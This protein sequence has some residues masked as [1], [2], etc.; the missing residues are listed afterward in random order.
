MA[1]AVTVMGSAGNK[2]AEASTN[3]SA[4][5]TSAAIGDL[6]LVFITADNAGASGASA[7]SSVTDAKGNTYTAVV[8]KNQTPGSSANDGLTVAIYK[9]VLTTALST[10]DLIT[11]NWSP[12]VTAKTIHTAKVTGANTT[13]LSSGSN[14]GAGTTYTVGPSASMTSGQ[15]II[16][17]AGNESATAPA[18]DTDTTNG[19]WVDDSAGGGSSGGT[20]GDGTKMASMVAHKLVTGT[21]TQTWNGNTGANTDWGALYVIY[22]IAGTTNNLSLSVTSTLTPTLTKSAGKVLTGIVAV[23]PTIARTTNKAL[24]V[25][26]ALTAGLARQVGKTLA[27]TVSLVVGLFTSMVTPNVITGT[28]DGTSVVTGTVDGVA[29]LT[30][31]LDVTSVITGTLDGDAVLAGTLDGVQIITGT[32]DG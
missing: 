27:N 10:T 20:G 29:T 3:T 23:T 9:S 5:P 8:S 24:T 16:C 14:S 22:D 28:L 19:S 4:H 17:L 25:T 12:N 26:A 18:I 15:L 11:V 6:M 32:L 30:A 7:I 13:A 21:G 1:I 2:T 31:T